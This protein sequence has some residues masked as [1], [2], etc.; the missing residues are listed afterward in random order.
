MKLQF[1][2][3]QYQAEAANAVVNLFIGQSNSENKTLIDREVRG[4]GYLEEEIEVYSYGNN[5]INIGESVIRQNIKLVQKDNNLDMTEESK[6]SDKNYLKNFSIEME[7]GTGKTYTYIKTMYELNKAY[8]FSKFIVMVPSIAI[9]EGTLKSFQITEEHF[10]EQYGKKIRYFVYNTGNSSNIAN[11]KSFSEDRNINVIIMNYQAFNAKSEE[12]RKIYQELDELQ[13]RKPIDIIKMTNPI[14]V[15][16][17]PQ[18]MGKA[19]ELL[20]EFN[21]LF[22]LRYS[23]THKSERVY[24]LIY[25]ID[26]VDAYNKKL[27]KKIGVKTCEISNTKNNDTYIYFENIEIGK[28]EPRAHIEIEIKSKNGTKKIL[29]WVKVGDRLFDLSCGLKEYEGYTVS[30]IDFSLDSVATISFSNGVSIKTNELI[31]STEDKSL[32]RAQ[33]RQTILSHFEKEKLLYY[34]NIKVLSLFFIDEVAKYKIYDEN[35]NP[36]NGEYADIFEEIYIEVYYEYLFK[37]LGIDYEEIK[38]KDNKELLSRIKINDKTSEYA[39]YLLSLYEK[40][41]HSGYFSIDK[42]KSKNIEKGEYYFIDSKV[43]K[44]GDQKGETDDSDAFDLIMK[45]KER[46]LSFDEPVRFIFSHSALREGWDNP[47]VFQICTLKKNNSDISK[48]QEIGRG[49]RI[50]VNQDGIRQDSEVLDSEFHV[51]NKLTV[52]ASESYDEFARSLQDEMLKSLSRKSYEKM[53]SSHFINKRLIA[54]DN[55]NDVLVIDENL[56]QDI[57]DEFYL[58]YKYVGKINGQNNMITDKLKEDI[59]ADKLKIPHRLEKYSESFK[60]LIK[61]LYTDIKVEIEN[62]NKTSI[63][64]VLKPNANFKKKEFMELWKRINYKT[65]YEVEFDSEELIKNA[66]KELDENLKITKSIVTITVGEQNDI[67]NYADIKGKKSLTIKDKKR[68]TEEGCGYSN[69]KYDLVGEISKE[70]NLTRK[71]VAIVLSKIKKE[72]FDMFKKSPEEFIRKASNLINEMKGTT[73]IDGLRY[74]KTIEKYDDNEVW[75]LNSMGARLGENAM[76][77]KHSVFDYLKYDS[78]I[79]KKFA[80][81]LELDNAVIYAKLPAKFYIDTPLGQYNPDWALCYDNKDYKYIYFVAETKGALGS[82]HLRPIEKSKIECAK[83]HFACIFDKDK[84]I[85]YEVFDTYE[86]LMNELLNDKK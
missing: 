85:G 66:V 51:V 81:E 44:S 75:T 19:E 43:A 76:E 18:K 7:T 82:A 30:Q 11:I 13:S 46:L 65:S 3:Q 86:K 1:K 17:E 4:I 56:Y 79:E 77:V 50:C 41:V 14:L 53:E 61:S 47:N 58:T 55:K 15:L 63:P 64:E 12:S 9:R 60:N 32:A 20:K 54:N 34:R 84:D 31:G 29:K 8:G 73:I 62:E 71:T 5:F 35:N 10:K 78:S 21:P 40:K 2:K 45:D 22:I 39:K 23:A 26:A 49:M 28:G 24:N 59:S 72:T 6:F 33:I 42:K 69:I 16:D 67:I 83:K 25:R 70:V 57:R 52:I 36:A 74:S 27:V 68:Y 48:R 80:E 37:E 38:N